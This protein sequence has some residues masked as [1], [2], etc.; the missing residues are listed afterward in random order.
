MSHI[1]PDE[2]ASLDHPVGY[3][4]TVR[5][6]RDLVWFGVNLAARI[7]REPPSD[8]FALVHEIDATLQECGVHELDMDGARGLVW[9]AMLGKLGI[10]LP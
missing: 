6:C 10:H 4:L 5:D 8:P 7:K 3:A 2:P 1:D 9:S